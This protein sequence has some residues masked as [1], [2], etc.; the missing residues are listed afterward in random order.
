M[1]KLPFASTVPFV[2]FRVAS[3][4][5]GVL[6]GGLCLA[7]VLGGCGDDSSAGSG[8]S[9]GSGTGSTTGSSTSTSSGGTTTGSTT[10]S[11]TSSGEGGSGGG[12]TG[13]GGSGAGDTGGGGAGGGETATFDA[14]WTLTVGP[15]EV[16]CYF[17]GA[18]EVRITLTQEGTDP[19]EETVSCFDGSA[20]LAAAPVGTYEVGASLLNYLGEVVG[21]SEVASAELEAGGSPVALSF[22]VP[23]G[24]IAASWIITEGGAPSTC[25]AAGASRG[26]LV[27]THLESGLTYG[28]TFDCPLGEG[29][30]PWVPLGPYEAIVSLLYEQDVVLVSSDVMEVELTEEGEVVDLPVVEFLLE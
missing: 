6:S 1:T 17:L 29:T 12:N 21:E 4:R 2:P 5:A 16:D 24:R 23:G 14:S 22:A 19:V 18:E 3:M 10:A 26:E 25:A 11:S 13:G 15:E 8:G 28:D 7:L 30:G 20:L 9:G 27:V